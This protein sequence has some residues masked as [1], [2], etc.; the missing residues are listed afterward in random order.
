MRGLT[1]KAFPLGGRWHG[2]AVTDEGAMIEKFRSLQGRFRRLRAASDFARGGKVTKTP[3]GDA[4]DGHFVPIG[5]L[6]PGP[7]FTGVTPLA[8][9]W[10]YGAQNLSDIPRFLPA[11]W[12]L[13]VWKIEADAVPHLR[14]ALPSQRSW[15]VFAVGAAPCGRPPSVDHDARRARPPGRAAHAI[16]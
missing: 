4:A 10:I 1:V 3:P 14:L 7:P 5:P 12:G 15:S 6:T 8:R 9:Y 2:E 13:T 16:P 11:H